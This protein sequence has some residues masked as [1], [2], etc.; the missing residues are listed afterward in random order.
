MLQVHGY[1]VEGT[2]LKFNKP[3]HDDDQTIMIK[4]ISNEKVQQ[5]KK[6]KQGKK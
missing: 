1:R 4:D 3:K 2:V 6:Q 5:T